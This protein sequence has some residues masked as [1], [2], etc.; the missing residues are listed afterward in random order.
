[1]NW[2]KG[3][4]HLGVMSREIN[5]FSSITALAKMGISTAGLYTKSKENYRHL[6]IKLRK[7]HSLS[8]A[9]F[10]LTTKHKPVPSQDK[11]APTHL[12]VENE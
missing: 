3:L 10:D 12:S 11:A 4:V 8:T 1:M 7:L 6:M 9:V 5:N 2:M